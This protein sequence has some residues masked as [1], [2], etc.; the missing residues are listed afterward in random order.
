MALCLF[1]FIAKLR[2]NIYLVTNLKVSAIFINSEKEV[3]SV[4][5]GGDNIVFSLLLFSAPIVYRL[6]S[7]ARFSNGFVILQFD[8]HLA[9]E[10]RASCL[11]NCIE[12]GDKIPNG[13]Q[14]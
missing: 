2:D 5:L 6:R 7:F 14:M 1:V 8:H 13:F 3:T 9:V 4:N 10:K 11:G 12:V